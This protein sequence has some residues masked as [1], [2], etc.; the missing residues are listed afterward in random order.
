MS[1]ILKVLNR[2]NVE[3]K[4]EVVELGAIQNIRKQSEKISKDFD[5][6]KKL[7]D[8]IKQIAIDSINSF[9]ESSVGASKLIASYEKLQEQAK[10]LGVE[11]PQ[12][13]QNNY[14]D[15]KEILKRGGD[16]IKKLQQVK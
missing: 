10:D 3:L 16:K 11:L 2:K 13:V 7:E 14:A 8:K 9:K 6:G 4:S 5:A 1:E 15:A 12:G